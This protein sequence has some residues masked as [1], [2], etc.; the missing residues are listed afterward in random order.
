MP[1]P[2]L[3][4]LVPWYRGARTRCRVLPLESIPTL[5]ELEGRGE[6]E[7]FQGSPENREVSESRAESP[8]SDAPTA[9]PTS[10]EPAAAEPEHEA[11]EQF[12]ELREQFDE[13]LEKLNQDLSEIPTATAIGI[14]ALGVVV[15]RLLPR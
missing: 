2:N 15:G 1:R 8:A 4:P 14:F 7:R 6:R 10:A 13:L 5:R 11:E 3:S 12:S 9:D